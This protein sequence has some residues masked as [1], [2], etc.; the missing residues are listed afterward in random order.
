MYLPDNDPFWMVQ[1]EINVC[2]ILEYNFAQRIVI[3]TWN[4]KQQLQCCISFWFL[5]QNFFYYYGQLGVANFFAYFLWQHKLEQ[6]VF[7]TMGNLFG[8]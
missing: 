8:S 3:G 5:N 6:N 2:C 7:C 4:H 1:S